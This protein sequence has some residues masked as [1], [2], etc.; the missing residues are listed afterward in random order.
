MT[1]QFDGTKHAFLVGYCWI[2]NRPGLTPFPN[3]IS[4][5]LNNADHRRIP[6]VTEAMFYAVTLP[7]TSS[8]YSFSTITALFLLTTAFSMDLVTW[9]I[10]TTHCHHE[11]SFEVAT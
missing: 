10:D 7:W 5:G 2:D 4:T 3:A 6:I 11:G 9:S 1:L 8:S